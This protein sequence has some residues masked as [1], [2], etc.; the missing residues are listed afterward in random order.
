MG[1]FQ[2]QGKREREYLDVVSSYQDHIQNNRITKI[3]TKVLK[4]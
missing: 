3:I 2:E 4:F 1:N